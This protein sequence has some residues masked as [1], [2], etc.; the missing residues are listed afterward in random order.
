M[1]RD[2]PIVET[3]TVLVGAKRTCR[4]GERRCSKSS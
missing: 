1:V 3:P 2:L 4:C